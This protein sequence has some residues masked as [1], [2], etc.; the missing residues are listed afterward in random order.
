M[1]TLI[2][3]EAK[4]VP[5]AMSPDTIYVAPLSLVEITVADA[6]VSHL[7]TLINGE[8]PISTP[9]GVGPDRHLRLSM[10]DIC[11][12][13]DGLVLPCQ[14]HVADLVRFTLDWD[15]QAPLLIHCWAGIS[16][17]T[18]AAFISLCALNPDTDEHALARTLRRASPTAFPN[19]LLVALADETLSRQG[20]MV[21]AVEHIG[22]GR[23]A[24]E[25]EP[26]ALPASLAA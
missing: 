13:R 2:M 6:Q 5:R 21:A 16:R 10:N 14:D 18:A 3:P 20:R 1:D 19:R 24:E 9:P 11:E 15:R 8:T 4:Q 23:L 7:V 22:R 25:A 12:P 26:F 17:S